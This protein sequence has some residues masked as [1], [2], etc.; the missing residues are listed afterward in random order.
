MADVEISE[1]LRKRIVQMVNVTW[2]AIGPDVLDAYPDGEVIPLDEVAQI[3]ADADH[4]YYM[5]E[6]KEAYQYWNNLPSFEQ[7]MNLVINALPDEGYCK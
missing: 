4:M 6:D 5:G 3:V 2:Q 7:K 1:V